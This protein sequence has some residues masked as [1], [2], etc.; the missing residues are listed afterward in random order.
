MNFT[1][2]GS[3][4]A[5]C[6]SL[7]D[8]AEAAARALGITYNIDTVTDMNAIIDA[9]VMRTPALAI[10]GKVVIEGKVPS[11]DDIKRLIE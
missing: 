10:D 3:G 11:A 4:C 9:G 1:V 5:K 6:H 8:R 2:Y 7:F